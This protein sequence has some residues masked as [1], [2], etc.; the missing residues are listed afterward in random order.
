LIET[1][2]IE[3]HGAS[4]AM[5]KVLALRASQ[6]QIVYSLVRERENRT[7]MAAAEFVGSAA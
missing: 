2:K 4:P 1:G 6:F 7:T 3:I 5:R